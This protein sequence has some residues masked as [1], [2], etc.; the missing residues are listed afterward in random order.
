MGIP[1]RLKQ[2]SGRYSLVDSIPF[3]L[4]VACDQ[5]PVLMAVFPINADKADRLLPGNELHAFRLWNKGL[6]VFTVVNYQ[7]TNIG[8]Y[9]E[10]SIAIACTHGRKR[11][12]RLLPALFMKH[13]DV[14]QYVFDLPV[15]TQ[16]SVKGGK[17]IW[18]MPKH[19]CSLDFQITDSMVSSQY[20][21][22]GKLGVRVEI[23]RPKKTWLPFRM[24]AANF[25]EFRGM[26]MKSSIYFHGKIGFNL[27]KQGSARL[28]IGDVPRVQP[29][30]ELE[31]G[32]TPVMTAFI[33]DA[34]GILDD[35][36]EC[37]FLSYADAPKQV[38]EGM[39][40]VINLGQSQQWLAP[41][42]ASL[43]GAYTP[44]VKSGKA[45]AGGAS[46]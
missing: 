18:G 26:L 37:W 10:Y 2:Q 33:P 36:F 1:K 9:I 45:Q 29:L 7:I 44:E 3:K 25:C 20:D 6:L 12:P 28:Y 34:R 13:Y 32:A 14:G 42:T 19:Q 22:D 17:G 43:A 39:E 8:K 5:T 46:R 11:A 23:D 24:A 21:L 16:V 15:S 38:P 40:S 30:K 4:P 41:P 31:I 27:F 35:H